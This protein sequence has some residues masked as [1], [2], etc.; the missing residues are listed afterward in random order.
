MTGTN[1]SSLT[2]RTLFV[3]TGGAARAAAARWIEDDGHVSVFRKPPATPTPTPST[4]KVGDRRV[5]R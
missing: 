1:N 5:T 2:R 3:G 4:A